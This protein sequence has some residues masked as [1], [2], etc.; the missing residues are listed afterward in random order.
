M[1]SGRLSFLTNTVSTTIKSALIAE[2]TLNQ[3]T[4][5]SF[6]NGNQRGEKLRRRIL[7]WR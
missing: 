5:E 6:P 2:L 4:G 1:R 3:N 7:R